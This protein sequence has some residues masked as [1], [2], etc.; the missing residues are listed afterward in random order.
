MNLKTKAIIVFVLIYSVVL[1]V[2]AHKAY[3]II[4]NF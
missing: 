2:I 1:G 3:D 4:K